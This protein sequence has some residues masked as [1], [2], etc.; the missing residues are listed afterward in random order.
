LGLA[1]VALGGGRQIETDKID[2]A[3]GLSDVAG[4]GM[5]VARGQPIARVHAGREGLADRAVAAVRAAITL[6]EAAPER[7]VLVREVV[8]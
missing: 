4:L 7:R 2:P 6:G 8:R 5:R 3:V 1:V